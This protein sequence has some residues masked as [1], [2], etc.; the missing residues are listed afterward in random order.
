MQPRYHATKKKVILPAFLRVSTEM[1]TWCGNLCH[2]SHQEAQQDGCHGNDH[3]RHPVVAQEAVHL[4]LFGG[5]L[6]AIANSR[7]VKAIQLWTAQQC[8][9]CS[10]RVIM[11]SWI[12]MA[13]QVIGTD[14][15]DGKHCNHWKLCKERE[16][17]RERD[18]PEISQN[19][20]QHNSC[21]D[22]ARWSKCQIFSKGRAELWHEAVYCYHNGHTPSWLQGQ[23]QPR[24]VRSKKYSRRNHGNRLQQTYLKPDLLSEAC[25]VLS[26]FQDVLKHFWWLGCSPRPIEYWIAS[27]VTLG[28]CRPTRGVIERRQGLLPDRS[29]CRSPHKLGSFRCLEL[30]I[31]LCGALCWCILA[32]LLCK[33]FK[34]NFMRGSNHHFPYQ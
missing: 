10:V 11:I 1:I 24:W 32:Y 33:T 5:W 3:A 28:W 27:Q 15:S 6:H 4:V 23:H 9:S 25:P 30:R 12:H 8:C 19:T 18:P 22:N 31:S 2:Q 14:A 7:K 29:T 16:R 34:Y 26:D 13:L 21:A 20:M 17:E